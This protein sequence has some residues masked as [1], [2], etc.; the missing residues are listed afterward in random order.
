MATLRDVFEGPLES[1][2]VWRF[3]R[4]NSS[5]LTGDIDVFVVGVTADGDLVGFS[6]VSVET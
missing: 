2:T 3:G 1:V 5:G 6:T 4:R